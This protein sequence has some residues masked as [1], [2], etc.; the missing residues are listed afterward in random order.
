MSLVR[1]V[2]FW[3][4]R[5]IR[6]GPAD[7]QSYMKST[8]PY[9]GV[10]F[11]VRHTLLKPVLA[12][13]EPRDRTDFES[14]VRRLWDEAGF[15]E[16]RYAAIDLCRHRTCSAFQTPESLPLYWHMVVTGAWWDLVDEIAAHLVGGILRSHPDEVTPTIRAWATDEDL[17][18]R[19]TAIL[20]QIRFKDATD[21]DLLAE[22]LEANLEDSL[23]GKQFW[24]RKAVGWSLRSYA[25]TD[26]D[27][28][29][30]FAREHR[31]RLSGLSLREALKHLG[32]LPAL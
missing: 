2:A 8:M 5:P 25:P 20:A 12:S 28:V 23:H 4:L 14:T 31:D 22:V 13:Y 1:Y 10:S 26:A 11:P 17:W 19:R 29:L 30:R 21:T 27:F 24:I 7:M 3:L 18:L 15:R 16:E 9:R 32:G 6:S